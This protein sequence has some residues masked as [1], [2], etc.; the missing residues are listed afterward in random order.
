MNEGNETVLT[1]QQELQNQESVSNQK[2]VPT[3]R[4]YKD[5][6]FRMIFKEKK[7]LLSLYNAMNG[8]TY[9]NE[10]DLTITT[11][12][13]AIYMNMKND[14]S[15][16]ID[17]GLSLYEHQ[18]TWNPNIPLRNL[19]Y[20]ADLYS[21]LTSKENLFGKTLIKIPTPHF[22]VFYNGIDKQPERSFLQL[23][24]S[25]QVMEEE[26]E[27]ELKVLVLNINP[28][29]NMEL[30]DKC[31]TLGDYV[32]YVDRVRTYAKT[33]TLAET[34]ERAVNECI[35][36]DILAEFLR[37]Y[38]AEAMSVSIYE[39]DEEKHMR[40]TFAEGKV[41]GKAE[42]KIIM[43]ITLI[44][45]KYIKGKS[46]SEIA[47]DLEENVDNLKALYKL[48]T[49]NEQKTAEEIYELYRN[50]SKKELFNT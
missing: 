27:L 45:K 40:Q 3:Q 23:S 17:A 34:V 33:M 39:Y 5:R 19:G 31:K 28:G 12:D 42:E 43:Q 35:K 46:L 8:T 44:Q 37:N 36:D 26:K 18:S 11:L 20:V 48:V 47:D 21:T 2:D 38:K 32:K 15:F 30:M 7:E 13:N 4:N 1:K 50:C 10:N 49:E 16:L 9:N 24:D 25:F 6:L 29:Y 41:E 22:V 14:L